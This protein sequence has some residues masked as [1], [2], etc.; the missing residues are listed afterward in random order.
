M[1]LSG[2]LLLSC[3]PIGAQPARGWRAFKVADGLPE[4][5]CI[6][7]TSSAHGH[8]VA[9]YL[10][11]PLVSDLDG[12]SIT[13]IPSAGATKSRVYRSPAGQF[14][15]VVPEG[16][17]EFKSGDWVLYP[18]PEVRALANVLSASII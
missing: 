17:M 14:W 15:T 13:N 16:L 10:N 11:A 2:I 4:S 7:V 6:S 18:V 12:Y 1:L 3:N 5:A 8:V 9:R